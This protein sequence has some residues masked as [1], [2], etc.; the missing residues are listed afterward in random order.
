MKRKKGN[1][2]CAIGVE[3]EW[4]VEDAMRTLIRAEEIEKDKKLMA[5]VRMFAQKRLES[6]AKIVGSAGE[7]D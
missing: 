1:V 5:K 4:M 3:E 6:T 7:E 2:G